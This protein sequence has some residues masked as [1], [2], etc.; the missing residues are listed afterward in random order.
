MK[1]YNDPIPSSFPPRQT[2]NHGWPWADIPMCNPLLDDSQSW[3]RISI[4]TPSFNQGNFLEE[5]IRSVILQNYPNLE[6]III[7]GGS[8]DN[9][10]E[11]IKKFEP[12]LSYWISEKDKGQSYA[13]NKGW[14][15][16]SGEIL[17]WLNSD[18]MLTP[19]AL[20]DVAT[21]WKQDNSFGFINGIT[22]FI[23]ENSR[24]IGNVFGSE[25]N[26]LETIRTSNNKV[27]QPSTFISRPALESVGFLDNRL[28]M[29]MDWDL[30]LRIGSKYSTRFV[31][32]VWSR[33]R[34]W[35]DTKTSTSS[36]KSGP[37]HICITRKFFKKNKLVY[38][39]NIRSTSL[40]AAYGRSAK[41]F[42][43]YSKIREFR[44]AY[45]LSLV[46]SPNLKGGAASKL[47]GQAG[48]IAKIYLWLHA[49]LRRIEN[50]ISGL[51]FT[52][53]S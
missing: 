20:L 3:P 53:R 11:V 45:L 31:P 40:A 6:Y 9:S 5:T 12:W 49:L 43:R 32:H 27:A 37:E 1:Q 14:A 35:K 48:S 18:D 2:D 28:N 13:I 26:L 33:M 17:A 51:S 39:K 8:T 46:Y 30:W 25:F 21:F 24:L 4:V 52:Q 29:S 44:R 16:S 42:H 41:I 22:E 34:E 10:I 47:R 15:R 50:R 7:D 38:P 23:D 19:G 36:Y